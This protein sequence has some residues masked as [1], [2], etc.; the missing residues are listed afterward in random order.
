MKIELIS[1]FGIN[2]EFEERTPPDLNVVKA[3]SFNIKFDKL[4]SAQE[5][6]HVW[7]TAEPLMKTIL[8]N[9]N[10]KKGFSEAKELAVN[11][12]FAEQKQ[13]LEQENT[14]KSQNLNRPKLKMNR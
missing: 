6:K 2:P 5:F 8:A 3:K 9:K 10:S 4:N 14:M 13:K 7:E 1:L 11:A 12:I